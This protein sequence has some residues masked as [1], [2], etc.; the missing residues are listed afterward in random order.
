MSN[1]MMVGESV[2]HH[3]PEAILKSMDIDKAFLQNIDNDIDININK[4]ILN[5]IAIDKKSLKNI[6][7]NI[8]SDKGGGEKSNKPKD[9]DKDK[10]TKR[11]NMC[12]IFE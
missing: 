12:Y 4:A 3:A 5:N 7:I 2:M 9:N 11:P 10:V 1:M 6:D 8:D